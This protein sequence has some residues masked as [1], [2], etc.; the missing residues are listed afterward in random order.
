MKLINA[1]TVGLCVCLIFGIAQASANNS[2]IAKCQAIKPNGDFKRMK[3]KKNCFRD[4]S[5]KQAEQL[6]KLST[7]SCP[8]QSLQNCPTTNS[9]ASGDQ[10]LRRVC[11]FASE[12][13]FIRTSLAGQPTASWMKDM[14]ANA[15]SHCQGYGGWK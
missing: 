8:K 4:L 5:A 9:P 6:A 2:E 15:S 1:I 12:V 13:A 3:Q 7:K 11:E 14:M 10:N